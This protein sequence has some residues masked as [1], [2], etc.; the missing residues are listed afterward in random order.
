MSKITASFNQAW[1][2]IADYCKKSPWKER[3]QEHGDNY[4]EL[5]CEEMELSKQAFIN[6]ISGINMGP[7]TMQGKIFGITIE[8]FIE[9]EFDS[10]E[11]NVAVEYL[12]R[13]KWKMSKESA[14]CLEEMKD[15]CFTIYEVVDTKPGEYLIVKDILLDTKEIK[16][17]EESGS[18]ALKPFDLIISKALQI[19]GEYYFT[20]TVFTLGHDFVKLI[21]KHVQK[22]LKEKNLNFKKYEIVPKELLPAANEV[23][24]KYTPDLFIEAIRYMLT[25]MTIVNPNNEV[26]SFNSLNYIIKDRDKV[27]EK[28]NSM[29]EFEKD[30]ENKL[31]WIYTEPRKKK[32]LPMQQKTISVGDLEI[33]GDKLLCNTMTKPASERLIKLLQE[34]LGNL[35]SMPVIEHEDIYD[36]TRKKKKSPAKQETEDD[37]PDEIKQEVLQQ[38][39]DQHLKKCLDEK[40]PVLNNKTPRQCAKSDPKR[41]IKWLDMM[42]DSAKKQLP[43]GEYDMSWVYKELGLKQED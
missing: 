2:Q 31:F 23:L 41:V 22:D 7:E 5:F 19:N 24:R 6:K 29:P 28:L 18:R 14:V 15:R 39:Y 38:Y 4:L 12:K 17:F 8:T 30:D 27:I 1:Q 20:G 26:I 11:D 36:E 43:S 10:P 9:K 35:V 34:N 37:I 16:V 25:P 40:I 21:K 32:F 13:R 3:F 33:K 42:E